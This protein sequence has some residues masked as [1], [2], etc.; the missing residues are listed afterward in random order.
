MSVS[1]RLRAVALLRAY[2]DSLEAQE[3][4]DDE[5][6]VAALDRALDQFEADAGFAGVNGE[7]LNRIIGAAADAQEKRMPGGA[8][9]F[10]RAL[11]LRMR[12]VRT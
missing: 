2:A 11:A 1:H 4:G 6:T 9:L 3:A 8:D 12:T 10:S 5:G 7:D